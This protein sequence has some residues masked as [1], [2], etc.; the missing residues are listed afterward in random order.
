[1]TLDQFVT[2]PNRTALEDGELLIA[3]EC[4]SLPGYAGSFE[5]VGH[6]RSLVI[7]LVCLA[8][9]VKLDAKAQR[10]ED[11]RLSIAGNRAEA[12]TTCRSREVSERRRD[13]SGA[14]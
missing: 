13:R 4:D 6:R 7:S 9:L 14:A 12:I 8:A 10:I 11:V 1:M 5:K 3:I 2:G